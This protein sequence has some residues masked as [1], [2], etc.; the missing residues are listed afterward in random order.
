M[1]LLHS[2]IKVEAYFHEVKTDNSQASTYYSLL[3]GIYLL[4]FF[5]FCNIVAYADL[6]PYQF[7]LLIVGLVVL[8]STFYLIQTQLVLKVNQGKVLYKSNVFPGEVTH[9]SLD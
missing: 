8:M 9:M 5:G 7:S 2:K 4:R 6:F 1:R 3:N